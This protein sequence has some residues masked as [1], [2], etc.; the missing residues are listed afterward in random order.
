MRHQ[1]LQVLILLRQG[2]ITQFIAIKN[3]I[4]SI[5]ARIA[6]L[7]KLGYEIVCIKITDPSHYGGTVKFGQWTLVKEP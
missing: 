1:L 3:G 4:L 5:T 6:D 7:R 2:P